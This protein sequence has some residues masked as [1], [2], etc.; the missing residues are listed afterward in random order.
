MTPGV[1][2][3][4]YAAALLT[5]VAFVPQVWK[6][7]R[8]RSAGDLSTAM[9]VIFTAGVALWLVYGLLLGS[10]PIIAANV[11]TLALSG[12]LVALRLRFDRQ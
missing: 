7:W 8:T 12:L 3:V 5:T 6:T 2:A 1:E 9:L 10:A 11:A 4:G